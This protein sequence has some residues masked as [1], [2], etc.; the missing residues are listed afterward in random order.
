MF[1]T[2]LMKKFRLNN[3]SHFSNKDGV[4]CSVLILS[5]FI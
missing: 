4:L 1:L 5:E 3:I 2:I